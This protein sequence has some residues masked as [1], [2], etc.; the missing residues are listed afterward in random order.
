[1]AR[2][3]FTIR[4]QVAAAAD[5]VYRALTESPAL[6][7]WFAER[8]DVDLLSG[9][10][11]FWGRYTPNGKRGRQ[12]VWAYEPN[13]ML[14]IGWTLGGA[15]RICEFALEPIPGGTFLYLVQ[16][17]PPP[18]DFD[19]ANLSDFWFLSIANLLN[20]CEGLDLAERHDFTRTFPDAAK[21]EI[22]IRA[23]RTQ[24][25]DALVDPVQLERWIAGKAIVEPWVGGRYEFGWDHGPSTIVDYEPDRVLAYSW[26]IERRPDTVVRW[27][28]DDAPYGGGVV[29]RVEHSGFGPEHSAEGY[30][31]GWQNFLVE[32]KRMHELG[33]AWHRIEWE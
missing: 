14:R 20:F 19:A 9:R 5:D 24:V 25:F 3:R 26:R 22:V 18:W 27:E 21:A 6:A 17:N 8:A 12:R 15:E 13:R 4:A 31:I 11:E 30:Q 7:T 28:V 32:L 23:P 10:Y 29:A 2:G 33:S 16:D 1:M